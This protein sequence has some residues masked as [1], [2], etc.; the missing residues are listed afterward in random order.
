MIID[1]GES[2]IRKWFR[3]PLHRLRNI[4]QA[5]ITVDANLGRF[6]PRKINLTSLPWDDVSCAIIERA[7]N[8]LHTALDKQTLINDYMENF[9]GQSMGWT[10]MKF[11]NMWAKRFIANQVDRYSAVVRF[12]DSTFAYLPPVTVEA[13]TLDD[14]Q[15]VEDYV[16]SPQQTQ[17]KVIYDQGPLRR[18]IQLDA[19]AMQ[20]FP[21]I[22]QDQSHNPWY[23]HFT[24]KESIN[25][26]SVTCP[27]CPMTVDLWCRIEGLGKVMP[28]YGSWPPVLN[29]HVDESGHVAVQRLDRG[30]YIQTLL[31]ETPL[32]PGQWCNLV[33]TW[34]GRDMR[35]YINGQAAA[36]PVEALGVRTA[37]RACL[38]KADWY[39]DIVNARP[40][41]N[42]LEG[43]IAR[44]RTLQIALNSEQVMNLYQRYKD[45]FESNRGTNHLISIHHQPVQQ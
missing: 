16:F 13:P 19:A 45:C 30:H 23:A 25:L 5:N 8:P 6:Y 17:Q 22:K 3:I 4:P 29:V 41:R 42:M 14:P 7:G 21:A 20:V 37:E 44:F 31:S 12:T 18:D 38:G 24:G 33:A 10:P 35:L 43:D 2:V 27:P 1:N 11:H 9:D 40:I 34:D 32:Q 15:T 26:G 28:I 36:E 39:P